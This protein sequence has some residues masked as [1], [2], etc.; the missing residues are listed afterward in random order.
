MQMMQTFYVSF[1][2]KP[3]DVVQLYLEIRGAV[4]FQITS[5]YNVRQCSDNFFVLDAARMQM[6]ASRLRLPLMI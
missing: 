3:S 4:H 1:E 2:Q 6:T 5:V